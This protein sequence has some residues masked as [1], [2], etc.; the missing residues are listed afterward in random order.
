MSALQT[1]NIPL[2]G[3]LIQDIALS[4]DGLQQYTIAL[5]AVKMAMVGESM[6][7]GQRHMFYSK[8]DREQL[9]VASKFPMDTKVWLARHSFPNHIGFWGTDAW[10]LDKTVHLTLILF[11]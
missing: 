6:S 9:R 7:R 1:A 2:M 8:A 5:W 11:S 4:L 10:S 3:N